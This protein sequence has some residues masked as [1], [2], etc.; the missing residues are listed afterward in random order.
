[1]RCAALLPVCAAGALLFF[2]AVRRGRGERT[3]PGGEGACA[4]DVLSGKQC[5]DCRRQIYL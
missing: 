3:A 2:V 1:M 4:H 5:A